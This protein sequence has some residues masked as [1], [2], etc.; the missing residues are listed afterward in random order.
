MSRGK[1]RSGV[2]E[3]PRGVHRVV[4]RGREYFYFQLG[5]GTKHEGERVRL[6]DDP[7][8]PDFWSAL[9]QAQGIMGIT[10]G[11]TVNAAIDDY[12]ASPRFLRLGDGTQDQ[13][14]R[15]LKIAR[16]AWGSLPLA[17]LEP[18]HVQQVI[19]GLIE[20]PGKA[21][22]F[23]GALR[24]LSRWAIR[25]GRIGHS[26]TDS[27]EGYDKE[28]GHRPWTPEQIE[29][30]H[31]KLSGMVRRGV[32][33]GLYTG[34]RGSDIVRLGWTYVDDGGFDL[35]QTKTGRRIY[36]PIVPELTREM[37]GWEKRPGPFLMQE[38]GRAHG[39]PY[40]RKLFSRHFKEARDQ[41]PDLAGV[42][43]HGLRATAVVRL[44]R[45]GLSTGQIGDIIGMSLAMIE[46]YCRFADQKASGKAA[47]LYLTG[48]RTERSEACKTTAKL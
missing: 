8:S 24:A 25:A 14:K 30:A 26:L 1:R 23:L 16:E 31:S 2:V 3:L 17:G 43:M 38:D 10:H 36:C 46:R 19:D 27:V 6:P 42:T 44:R 35:G 40:T 28:G 45:A 29:A 21:N 15:A 41:I 48:T 13:Y 22:N 5:R 39:K 32:M 11:E 9:R 47:L 34:Q 20:T 33:L 18:Q 37:E 4:A 7:Q 12:L